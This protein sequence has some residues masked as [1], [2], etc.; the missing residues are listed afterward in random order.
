MAPHPR[1]DG[2]HVLRH[3]PRVRDAAR[4]ATSPSTCT[5]SIGRRCRTSPT[6]SGPSVAELSERCGPP[7]GE[8]PGLYA[9][10]SDGELHLMGDTVGRVA[11]PCRSVTADEIEHL[12][13]HGW[14]QARGVRRPRR[15]RP[16]ARRGARADGRGRRR[17]PVAPV[18][19]GRGGRGRRRG[20]STSTPT[21]PAA[22][23]NPVLRPVIEQVGTTA[24]AMLRRRSTRRLAARRPLLPG[25]AG[26]RSCRR[27]RRRATAAT[28]RPRST[29]TSSPSPS[30]G[31]AA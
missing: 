15:P 23:R 25:P 24:K 29:R 1:V 26:A 14:V 11:P 18:R 17:Q 7:E 21:A 22:W 30:T 3:R 10:R 5:T 9:F 28:A 13:E 31:P 19:R 2:P 16:R 4:S 8:T 12:H 27:R 6:G 20:R